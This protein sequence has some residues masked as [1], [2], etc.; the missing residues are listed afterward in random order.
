MAICVVNQPS[1]YRSQPLTGAGE[2]G[3]KWEKNLMSLILKRIH[4]TKIIVNEESYVFPHNTTKP[5][6]NLGDDEYRSQ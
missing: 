2:R 4:S 5:R 3:I 6:P 1:F